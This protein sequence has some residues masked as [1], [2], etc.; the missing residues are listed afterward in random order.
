MNKNLLKILTGISLL[1]MI[2]CILL[3]AFVMTSDTGLIGKISAAFAGCALLNGIM[4]FAEGCKKDVAKYFRDYVL[5]YV[6]SEL[7][8]I[9][10]ILTVYES[11]CLPLVMITVVCYGALSI[12]AFAK[13]L[14]KKTSCTLIGCTVLLK[15]AALIYEI[16]AIPQNI[17]LLACSAS[18]FTLA[19]ALKVMVLAKYEDKA[20]RGR[21]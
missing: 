6:V 21:N 2:A 15:I 1:F 8:M 16:I 9:A 20:S 3:N 7:M 14:G 18:T 17:A 12:L 11:N 10:A 19:Y 13:D 4:Y 5:A